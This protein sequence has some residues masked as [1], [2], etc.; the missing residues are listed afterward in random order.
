MEE[1]VRYRYFRFRLKQ[2]S[3]AGLVS[4]GLMIVQPNI[5]YVGI[6]YPRHDHIENLPEFIQVSRNADQ[7][8][9]EL[10][11]IAK[12]GSGRTVGRDTPNLMGLI[13]DVHRYGVVESV[14][15]DWLTSFIEPQKSLDDRLNRWFEE[16]RSRLV[17]V[18]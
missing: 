8:A 6:K 2:R 7:I 15:D 16:E 9:Q 18:D 17:V 1:N 11:T 13:D 10:D 14:G 5:P 3:P 4:V 12:V